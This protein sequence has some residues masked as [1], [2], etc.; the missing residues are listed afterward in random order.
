[1]TRKAYIAKRAAIIKAKLENPDASSRD[2]ERQV[3]ADHSVVCR[4]LRDAREK[5]LLMTDKETQ[6]FF[7][8]GAIE[9]AARSHKK[10][11]DVHAQDLA[12]WE[13]LFQQELDATPEHALAGGQDDIDAAK[14]NELERRENK[15]RKLAADLAE[16]ASKALYARAAIIGTPN[17]L[18][19]QGATFVMPVTINFTRSSAKPL[20][21]LRSDASE[22][23]IIPEEAERAS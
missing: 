9:A 18:N 15:R 16:A 8:F 11:I 10:S 3:G 13:K 21:P 6:D 12:R 5:G 17:Q 14:V 23:V 19:Q 4:T 7:T 1:M 2:I 22:A 20:P